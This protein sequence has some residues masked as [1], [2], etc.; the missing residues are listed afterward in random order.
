M[1]FSGELVVIGVCPQAGFL[2]EQNQTRMG[3]LQPAES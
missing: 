2:K 1:P 3:V